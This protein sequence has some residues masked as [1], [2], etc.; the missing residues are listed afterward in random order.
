MRCTPIKKSYLIAKKK[1]TSKPTLLWIFTLFSSVTMLHL[2]ENTGPPQRIVLNLHPLHHKVIF[3][4]GDT[5]KKIYLLP[6]S[7]QLND[8]RPLA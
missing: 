2:P 1:P 7:M 5:A 8:I 3:L 6:D 4:F